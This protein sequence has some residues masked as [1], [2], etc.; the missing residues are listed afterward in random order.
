MLLRVLKT[1]VISPLS[2][3]SILPNKED[4]PC[5]TPISLKWVDTLIF[6][7]KWV[8]IPNRG[9]IHMRTTHILECLMLVLV[10][11][12]INICSTNLSRTRSLR[13]NFHF[14][15]LECYQI[16]PSWW[17]TPFGTILHGL[18]YL[19]RFLLTFQSLVGRMGKTPQIIS[20][21]TICGVYPITFWMILSSCGYSPELLLATRLSG[22]LNYQLPLS[23]ISNPWR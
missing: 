22:S 16:Y 4:M 17:M 8:R 1:L 5:L 3:G 13:Q 15:L 20:L 11:I 14:L 7:I 12:S 9:C 10:W 23:L 19:S 21:H 18:W 2:E 6:L